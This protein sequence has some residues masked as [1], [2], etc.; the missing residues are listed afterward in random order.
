MAEAINAP[1]F[2][3]EYRIV[4]IPVGSGYHE[5]QPGKKVDWQRPPRPGEQPPDHLGDVLAWHREA[6]ESQIDHDD[7]THDGGNPKDVDR[8]CNGWQSW[9]ITQQVHS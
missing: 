5:E 8:L 3:A 9:D 4:E 2:P 6:E 7:R 1:E